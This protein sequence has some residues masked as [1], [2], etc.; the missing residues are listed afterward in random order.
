MSNQTTKDYETQCS[1]N[2]GHSSKDHCT[3]KTAGI[4]PKSPEGSGDVCWFSVFLS[5]E[6][7]LLLCILYSLL[8]KKQWDMLQE[9]HVK[10]LREEKKT[11]KSIAFP[12]QT[13][14]PVLQALCLHDCTNSRLLQSREELEREQ[15]CFHVTHSVSEQHG[16]QGHFFSI[17]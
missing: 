4:F 8:E 10:V 17:S 6:Q 7:V 1:A 9:T 3:K 5:F 11:Q 2:S 12:L 16:P 14:Q 13:V 15:Q